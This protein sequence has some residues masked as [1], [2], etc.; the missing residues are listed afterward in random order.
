MTEK[1]EGRK[2]GWRNNKTLG[3][4]A[5]GLLLLLIFSL[6]L[7]FSGAAPPPE[8]SAANYEEVMEFIQSGDFGDL[9]ERERIDY[10]KSMMDSGVM[11][12]RP[13]RMAMSGKAEKNAAGADDGTPDSAKP[14]P[15]DALRDTMRAMMKERIN[16]YFDTPP[17]ERSAYLDK[18]ID[19]RRRH[20]EAMVKN[21]SEEER[22]EM[23]ENGGRPPWRRRRPSAKMIKNMIE[24]HSPQER[25]KFSEFRRAMRARRRARRG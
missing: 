10:V 1:N 14:P 3:L 2:M 20:H 13:R 6:C 19:E 4:V 15:N 23:I 18:L 8:P 11:P 21:M 17:K 25:A 12:P 16:G 9:P 24:S 7:M 5:G 22:K